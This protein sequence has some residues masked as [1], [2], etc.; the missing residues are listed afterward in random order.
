MANTIVQSGCNSATF[1]VDAVEG[2]GYGRLAKLDWEALPKG[3]LRDILNRSYG[4]MNTEPERLATATALFDAFYAAGGQ[5]EC[6]A[7]AGVD[8]LIENPGCI[9]ADGTHGSLTGYPTV[10][11]G[12]VPFPSADLPSYIRISLAYSASE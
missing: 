4:P 1:R 10:S 3:R 8:S 2:P 6:W 11:F 7:R 9:E 5:I 12:F